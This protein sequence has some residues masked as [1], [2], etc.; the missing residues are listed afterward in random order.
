[1]ESLLP[2][3]QQN[4]PQETPKP[5]RKRETRFKPLTE[6]PT[7]AAAEAEPVEKPRVIRK[8]RK[9]KFKA[10]KFDK[11]LARLIVNGE[12]SAQKIRDSLRVDVDAFEA[13][14]ARLT[15]EGLVVRGKFD[16]D[17]L[18][19]TVKGFDEFSALFR[20]TLAAAETPGEA[21]DAAAAN[22]VWDARQT[23]LKTEEEQREKEK[24]GNEKDALHKALAD[25]EKKLLSA[26]FTAKEEIDLEDAFKKGAPN[27]SQPEKKEAKQ[28]KER[29]KE[30][31]KEKT[32]PL[33]IDAVAT[34]KTELK[35]TLE[36]EVAKAEKGAAMRVGE[37]EVCELCRAPFKIGVGSTRSHPKYGHCFCGAAYH[38]D[39]YETLATEQEGKCVRCGK[40]LK[41][42]LDARSERRTLAFR[43]AARRNASNAPLK[44]RTL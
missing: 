21:E 8:P 22:V 10:T 24:Q 43:A 6:A 4:P 31:E 33:E 38:K 14:L 12:R 17:Y 27:D 16:N 9:K 15:G 32:K 29:E 23:L 2:T 37:N 18:S 39:C 3:E 1:M 26:S 34:S 41:L 44:T 11:A 19:F 35:K 25:E 30:K 20:K 28:K 13:A 5:R 40:K 7:E 36:T 42:A